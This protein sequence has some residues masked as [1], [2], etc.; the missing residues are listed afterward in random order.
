MTKIPPLMFG[1]SPRGRWQ[2][3]F[4]VVIG[5]WFFSGFIVRVNDLGHDSVSASLE[6]KVSLGEGMEEVNSSTWRRVVD[7]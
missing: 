7:S 6:E 2:R 4:K 5:R 3:I 1:G